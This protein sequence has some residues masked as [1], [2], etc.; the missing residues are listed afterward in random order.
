MKTPDAEKYARCKQQRPCGNMRGRNLNALPRP[1]GERPEKDLEKNEEQHHQGRFP[2][3]S[4]IG[5]AFQHMSACPEDSQQYQKRANP[6]REMNPNLAERN[7]LEV[8]VQPESVRSLEPCLI[9][10]RKD[11]P[12]RQG[13][14]G[15][16]QAGLA[17]T[18]PRTKDKL[19]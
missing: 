6:V 17:M 9:C 11:T 13:K 10:R 14:I 4:I 7:G 18:H 8:Q 16:C 12:V 15:Y 2:Q 1:Y 5:I 3:L 19:D